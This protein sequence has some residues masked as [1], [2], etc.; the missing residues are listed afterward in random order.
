MAVGT[1]FGLFLSSVLNGFA[2]HAAAG[3]A[4]LAVGVVFL[5][6]SPR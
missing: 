3:L 6:R 5:V 4:V 2:A 1:L